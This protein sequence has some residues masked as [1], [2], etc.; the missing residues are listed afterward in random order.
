MLR[1]IPRVTVHGDCLSAKTGEARLY[2]LKGSDATLYPDIPNESPY[3]IDTVHGVTL[4][5]FLEREGLLDVDLLKLDIEGAELAV[6]E[7]TSSDVLRRVRQITVEFHDWMYP[8]T[9][10][11]V[12]A[13]KDQ[14]RSYGFYCIRFS[15]NNGD[16][17]FV[18]RDMLN[19]QEYFYLAYVVRNIRGG[20]RLIRRYC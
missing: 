19:Y 15:G 7:T 14:L 10:E 2:R 18:R 11:N 12:E 9:R 4:E 13:L 5:G 6:L 8:E 1:S 16:V 3:K 20:L 17:L